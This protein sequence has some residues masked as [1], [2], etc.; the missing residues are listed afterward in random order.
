MFLEDAEDSLQWGEE[1][2]TESSWAVLAVVQIGGGGGWECQVVKSEW[3]LDVLGGVSVMG[4]MMDK[5]SDMKEKIS[6]QWLQ[7]FHLEHLGGWSAGRGPGIELHQGC[8]ALT[9][10]GRIC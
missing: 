10:T 8:A 2:S 5:V 4:S 1:R 7:S 9:M 3:I 6:H